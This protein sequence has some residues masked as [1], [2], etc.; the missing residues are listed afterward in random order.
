[1]RRLLT[2]TVARL[3]AR[4]G[5]RGESIVE[6]LAAVLICSLAILMLYTALSSAS[7]MNVGADKQS[8]DLQEAIIAIETQQN[9]EG[10]L[11]EVSIVGF[12]RTYSVQ[13]YG[14]EESDIKSYR[15]Q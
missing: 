2:Q 4:L 5:T 9:P 10:E 1:M 12:E 11:R 7:R 14:S 15:L 8:S 13:Y 3:R 6:T